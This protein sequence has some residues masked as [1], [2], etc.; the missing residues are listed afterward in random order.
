MSQGEEP[1]A[2][3]VIGSS[4]SK[5]AHYK[6]TAPDFN[7][8]DEDFLA[9]ADAVLFPVANPHG[10]PVFRALLRTI[11]LI[12]LRHGESARSTQDGCL[13]L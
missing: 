2:E 7:R 10:L 12:S 5:R 8:S 3:S 11:R 4:R 6:E 13:L 9:A 1:F